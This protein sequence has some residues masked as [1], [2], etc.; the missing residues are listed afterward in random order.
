MSGMDGFDLLAVRGLLQ[1][2]SPQLK[3]SSYDTILQV[4]NQ[5]LVSQ[6]PRGT[7]R[8]S[9]FWCFSLEK[10]FPACVFLTYN[11]FPC[12]FLPVALNPGHAFNMKLFTGLIVRSGKKNPSF[13][14]AWLGS[15]GPWPSAPAGCRLCGCAGVLAVP[16]RI[17][18]LIRVAEVRALPTAGP[19][20]SGSMATLTS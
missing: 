19:A 3:S 17:L 2:C 14:K 20:F 4:K 11:F 9:V 13:S 16:S 5:A 8:T 1:E 7:A 12:F 15:G 18:L 6:Q 10:V